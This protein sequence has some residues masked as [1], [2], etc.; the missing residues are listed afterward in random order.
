[1]HSSIINRAR[2]RQDGYD[3]TERLDDHRSSSCTMRSMRRE[4]DYG[5]HAPTGDDLPALSRLATSTLL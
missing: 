5:R 2:E 1:V 4:P 3:L